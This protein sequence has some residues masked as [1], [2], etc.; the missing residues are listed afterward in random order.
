MTNID[1]IALKLAHRKCTIYDHVPTDMG[2][3]YSFSE[4]HLVDFARV[5]LADPELLAELSKD[6]E[7]LGTAG[8]LM[9]DYVLA[10]SGLPE[11]T[12]LFTRPANTAEIEQRVAEA[13]ANYIKAMVSNRPALSEQ[14]VE[15][16]WRKYL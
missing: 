12:L 16:K 10:K 14:L 3:K 11:D 6:A 4:H 9:D 2:I 7:P 1:E 8:Q 5:L 15:G 13:C